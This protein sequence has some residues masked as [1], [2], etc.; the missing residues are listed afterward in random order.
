M[1]K[2]VADCFDRRWDPNG[3]R[4]ITQFWIR[5]AIRAVQFANRVEISTD[6]N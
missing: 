3:L 1:T 5:G 4:K 6:R 2:V